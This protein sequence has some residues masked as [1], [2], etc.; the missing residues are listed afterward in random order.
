MDEHFLLPTNISV[1]MILHREAPLAKITFER[2]EEE[3]VTEKRSS[4]DVI[5]SSTIP[6]DQSDDIDEDYSIGPDGRSKKRRRGKREKKSVQSA[7]TSSVTTTTSTAKNET[8][9]PIPVPDCVTDDSRQ[10]SNLSQGSSFDHSIFNPNPKNDEKP[11]QFSIQVVLNTLTMV[12]STHNCSLLNKF[13]FS[14]HKLLNGRPQQRISSPIFHADTESSINTRVEE[15]NLEASRAIIRKWWSYVIFNVLRDLKKKQYL[16]EAMYTGN[17]KFDWHKHQKLKKQYVSIYL[18][19]HLHKKPLDNER[20]VF[21]FTFD[22]NDK[23]TLIALE[24]KLNLEQIL[25]FRSFARS[26]GN[27]D[28]PKVMMPTKLAPSSTILGSNFQSDAPFSFLDY[29]HKGGEIGE[30]NSIK[31][32]GN[33]GGAITSQAS[34]FVYR[35]WHSTN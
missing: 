32:V 3:T 19:S 30:S 29:V 21:D 17:K 16:K 25:L 22:L 26:I 4:E 9:Q 8:I 15:R 12:L 35:R 28:V 33:L 18:R 27:K 31:T 10:I 5:S 34:I 24:E 7:D 11:P 20:S 2:D 14:T 23:E 6:T 13:T 1:T